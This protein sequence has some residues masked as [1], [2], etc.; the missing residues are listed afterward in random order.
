MRIAVDARE[1]AGK[2]T[3]VGRYLGE[4]LR[5]WSDLAGARSHE[6]FLCAPEAVRVPD[7]LNASVLTAAGTGTAWEQ[8]TL[9]RLVAR[10][11]ADILFAPGYSGPL[12][13]GVPMVV[14]VHDVSFAAHPEW[15]A[16]REGLRRRI[17]TRLSA[18]KAARVITVS[19][20][21]KQEIARHVGIPLS[22]IEVIYS[23]ATQMTTPAQPDAA[24]HDPS[25]LFVGSLF[26]RRHIP[27]LIAGF[28]QLASRHP[29]VRLDIVGDN[30]TRP[31]I[32][33]D[34]VIAKS[35]AS[36]RIRARAYVA[37]DE[38]A[39]LY[40]QAR[41]FVF[42]SEYEGFALTPLEALG[43]GV[44]VVLLDTDV[45]R[46]IYGA[47]ATYVERPD[48]TLIAGA[49]ERT[50]FDEDERTRVLAA[51]APQLERYSWPECAQRTLQ[52]LLAC[53]RRK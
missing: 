8:L 21:S 47:A 26:N 48:P 29:T 46:E 32:D 13:T 41:A 12:G 20:F 44:P 49:L 36:K 33:I 45:A 27:E 9:P 15:F 50:L 18:R 24:P 3:G 40:R 5:A 52:V 42:L 53:A 7:S 39:A 4:L 2:P 51:A 6:F 35:H 11:N 31:H 23:G 19:D 25:V 16:W 43:A 22:N 10:A 17:V 34:G 1:L 30:R 37:D 14:T 38:L 28:E